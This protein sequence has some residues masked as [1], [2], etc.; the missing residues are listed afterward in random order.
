MNRAID[1]LSLV[2]VLA[3]SLGLF[4]AAFNGI[5]ERFV[6]GAFFLTW[7]VICAATFIVPEFAMITKA[8]RW[9]FERLFVPSTNVWSAIFA[10]VFLG[11]GIY[12]MYSWIEGTN[13][14]TT[15]PVITKQQTGSLKQTQ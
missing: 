14:T 6:E 10:V 9:I 3:L 2:T 8:T 1:W 15:T 11:Y 12:Q 7:G 4:I 13:S 5:D